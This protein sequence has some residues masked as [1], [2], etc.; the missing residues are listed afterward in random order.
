MRK[1]LTISIIINILFVGFG[2][3]VIH[4]KGGI[5]Y[6]ERKF[7]TAQTTQT[8]QT[9]QTGFGVYYEA[10]KQFF[11]SMPNDTNE[12]IFLGNS[13]TEGC[14]WVELFRNSKIKNR[15][16]SGDIIEGVINRINEV[17]ESHPQKIFLLIGTNDLA[18]NKSIN[19]ILSDYERLIILIKDKTPKTELYIQ[20]ILPTHNQETRKNGDILE[21]NKGL[22]KLSAKYNSVFINLFESFRNEKNELDLTYSYDGLHLNGNGYLLWKKVIENYVKN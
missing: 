13:I 8:T 9:T 17:V 19:Q 4:K 1:A 12:I 20:S 21:I 6:L 10:K 5:V 14:D 16:I 11:E 22:M 7:K 18:R 15:G 2:G 3:Y